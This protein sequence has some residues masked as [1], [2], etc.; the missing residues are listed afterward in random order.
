MRIFIAG[1]TGFIGQALI[2]KL[3]KE[4]HSVTALARN[5]GKLGDLSSNIRPVMGSPLIAGAWQQEVAGHE[6]IINLTGS[7][8]FTR[9]TQAAKKIILHSRLAS[10]Q[11][12]V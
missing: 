12:N 10:T 3:A 9:W 5:P 4:G 1:G 8:I 11:N 2:G 6:I 7:N